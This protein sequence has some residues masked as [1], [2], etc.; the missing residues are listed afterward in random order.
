MG[1]LRLWQCFFKE[2]FTYKV[3]WR[4]RTLSRK[5]AL[6]VGFSFSLLPFF[7]SHFL[8]GMNPQDSFQKI[9]M[10]L[11]THLVEM[12][13][14]YSRNHRIKPKTTQ[15]FTACK[16]SPHCKSNIPCHCLASFAQNTTGRLLTDF[17][18]GN[19]ERSAE[20]FQ[21]QSCNKKVLR[22]SQPV[23]SAGAPGR[24]TRPATN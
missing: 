21:N 24:K 8:R 17:S 9:Q 2:M 6:C 5:N 19:P 23:Q 18:I 22:S 15:F 3:Q 10:R 16:K 4:E 13:I 14:A 20:A 11:V 1:P 12:N 7:P